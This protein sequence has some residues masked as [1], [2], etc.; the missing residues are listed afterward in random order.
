MV[1]TLPADGE[2][3]TVQLDM[4]NA[5]N[6]VSR[7]AMLRQCL[8]K[9]PTT[10]S[11]L[12]WCYEQPCP[13]FSQGQQVAISTRGVHQGDAMGP[14]GFALG[15]EE[16]LDMVPD[17][18]EQGVAW[19]VWYL[20]DGTIS[21]RADDVMCF[22]DRLAVALGKIGLTSQVCCLRPGHYLPAPFPLQ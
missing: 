7:L 21:G 8:K 3:I 17:D 19:N 10:Y 13:L 12:A 9:A 11:W 16:A 2:W 4:T 5:F 1:D 18:A 20:D 22:V 14:L 6:S 15:L